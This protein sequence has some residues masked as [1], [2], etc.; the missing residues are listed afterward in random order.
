MRSRLLLVGGGHSHLFVLE[1]FVRRPLAD[2]EIVLVAPAPLATY[3]GMVPG[4][5]AGHYPLR[6]AQIDVRHLAVRAGARFAAAR[7]TALDPHQRTVD[8]SDGTRQSYDL[9]SFDIG[10]RA[11][12]VAPAATEAPLVPIK[13]IEPALATI[14]AALG[15]RP[16]AHVVVV[17]AGAAGSEVA[18]AV[19]ARLRGGEGTVTLCD[20][21]PRPLAGF[22]PRAMALL[23]QALD[24]ADVAWRGGHAVAALE[25][26]AV[27]LTDGSRLPADLIVATG[28]VTGDGL[29]ADAGLAVDERGFLLVD[30]TLCAAA[31]A[32]VFA[33]GDCATLASHPTLPK[34]GVY[35]VRQGPL[36]AANLRAALRGE[37]RRPYRPQSRALALL[38]TADGRAI[39]NYGAVAMHGRW[40]WRLKDLVDRRFVRRFDD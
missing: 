8:L 36:L 4:V 17:G 25:A 37:P 9:I 20:R 21:A 14:E 7:V 39:L 10:A 40:A 11:A 22:A 18:L 27:R 6:A 33:A 13:P 15:A 3:S 1:S 34:A 16:A 38:N 35:A 32:E 26:D 5:L 23:E 12:D 24:A 28:G 29:F 19:R 30:D 31:C 2:V